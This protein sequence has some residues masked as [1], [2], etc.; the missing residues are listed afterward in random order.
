MPELQW[1]PTEKSVVRKAFNTAL[2][3]DLEATIHE[4]KRRAD[5]ITEL[6]HLWELE[7]W[8]KERRRELDEAY[9]YRYSVLHSVFGRLIREGLLDEKELQG[10]GTEKLDFIRR[11]ASPSR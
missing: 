9:D 7:A 10:L 3:R 4:A 6:S 8:I 11:I 5:K 2:E 1:S